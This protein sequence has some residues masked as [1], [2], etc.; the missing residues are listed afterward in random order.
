MEDISIKDRVLK[1]SLTCTAAS[2]AESVTYPID[3]VKTRLQLQGQSPS[4]KSSQKLGAIA[5]ARDIIHKEGFLG[6]YAGL[7]PAITRH[8]FYTGTRITVYEQLRNHISVDYQG[9]LGLGT[10]LLLGLTAGAIGQTIA[11]PADLIKVRMQ[12]DGRMVALK[13]RP[14]RRYKSLQSAFSS[15]L[16]EE[17]VRG[18]WRGAGPAVQRAALVNL[19]ELTTYDTAK[20][21]WLSSG[22]VK[23]GVTLHLLS[24]VCSG[25]F[26]SVISVPADVIKTR[27][28]TQEL[29][30]SSLSL[31]SSSSASQLKSKVMVS[32]TILA[33]APVPLNHTTATAAT[34]MTI[35]NSVV[36]ARAAREV[37]TTGTMIRY[38]GSLD[39]LQK[40]VRNEGFG[41]L[42]KGFFPTWARL[43]PWQLVFWTTYEY[44]RSVCGMGS[45]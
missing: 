42:Y 24:A 36:P 29:S 3:M 27:M 13:L 9:S 5:L 18:L 30:S 37:S 45:F 26:A 38:S 14:S 20:R 31:S 7:S 43:G 28:M 40:T 23:E 39:C 22:L 2:V 8:I 44:V 33:G 35:D 25:F 41:A 1:L 32:S 21:A 16:A 12:A 15:I 11:V 6:I 10:K 34:A 19:G 4:I 17:G